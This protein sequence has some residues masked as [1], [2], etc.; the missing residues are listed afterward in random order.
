LRRFLPE[1]LRPRIPERRPA[2]DWPARAHAR[3][4]LVWQGCVQPALAPDINAAAARV[5]DRFGIRLLASGDGCCGALS[6]HMAAT[7][8]GRDF[9]RRT[10]DTLWP[11][12]EAGVEAIVI[13]A[14]GCG[15]HF[16]DYGELLHDDPDYRDKAA[17][18]S[19][20]ARDIA[21]IVAEEWQPAPDQAASPARPKHRVAFQ[22]SCSL[23]HG[24]KLNGV[25]EQ[26]LKQAGFKLV[27]VSYRFMCCGAAGSYSLLQRPLA[28]ALRERKLE[29][30]LASRP[31]TI[32]TANIGCLAHLAPAAPLPVRH[33]IEL[34]DETLAAAPAS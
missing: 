34:L 14:S 32:V 3:T 33:W 7:G 16:R 23:Q 12:V 13:T 10:I 24:E 28:E 21:E 5:L 8:E 6:H 22:S 17:R 9:M 15:A 30:L 26:L 25:V 20:L 29:T 11:Q 18:I 1:Q 2:G 27:P 4:M 31:E 19:A